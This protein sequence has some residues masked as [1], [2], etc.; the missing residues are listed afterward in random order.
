MSLQDVVLDV[1][2]ENGP[3]LPAE[4][5]SSV[6]QKTGKQTDMFFIGA[7]LSEL[8]ESKEVK[9]SFAKLGGSKLY[10]CPGQEAKLSRLYEYLNDK[11]K[12]AYDLLKEKNVLRNSELDPVIRVALS[13]LK[14]FARSIEVKLNE[15]ELFWCWHLFPI[16]EAK[17]M[18]K[19]ILKD[20]IS[21]F[22]GSKSVDV[23]VNRKGAEPQRQHVHQSSS[24]VKSESGSS[25]TEGNAT[26][27]PNENFITHNTEKTRSFGDNKDVT[28]GK[29]VAGGN[30]TGG[31]E[32]QRVRSDSKQADDK[33]EP[34]SSGEAQKDEHQSSL[35]SVSSGLKEKISGD[36]FMRRVSEFFQSKYIE[37]IDGDVL[38]K[39]SE[40]E[41]QVYVKSQIG[42]ITYY[43]FAKSKKK[44]SETDIGFA[45]VRAQNK[46]LP[47]C[48]VSQ[49]DLTK[50]AEDFLKSEL[51]SANFLKIR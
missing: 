42:M 51:K 22:E 46:N 17:K 33:Q 23:S 36:D 35:S 29:D 25:A 15:T 10:Y 49:G 11:E 39:N 45:Y 27:S 31:D 21:K 18:I 14:D 47:L 44:I 9:M 50:K 5:V 28:G 32:R 26:R 16:E 1:V 30:V 41:F 8:M 24:D 4:I 38:K 40:C 43:V 13:Q 19:E 37:I 6:A 3:V 2:K 20:D 34:R 7:I 48:F 12:K